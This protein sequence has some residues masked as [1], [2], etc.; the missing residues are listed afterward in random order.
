MGKRKNWNK[1]V[2]ATYRNYLCSVARYARISV[3]SLMP[4]SLL[5]GRQLVCPGIVQRLKAVKTNESS[6]WH[7][8]NVCTLTTKCKPQNGLW[9][10][11]KNPLTLNVPVPVHLRHKSNSY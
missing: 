8:L 6:S 11:E 9:V 7:C 3:A 2:E 4:Q 5:E 10:L 1:Q